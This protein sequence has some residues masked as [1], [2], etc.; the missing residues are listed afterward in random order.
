M[1]KDGGGGGF[2]QVSEG[3]H[4]GVCYSIYDLGT[5]RDDK[6]QKDVHKVLLI[7]ELPDERIEVE[8]NGEKKDLPRV[9]SKKYTLSLGE[10]A[11]LRKDLQTWRG[12]AFTPEELKGFDLKNVLSKNC[13]LQVIHTT[14]E[15][16]KTYANVA[17]II[18]MPKNSAKF[19]PENPVRFFSFADGSLEIPD[20]TPDWIK[21]EIKA[22][23]EWQT[24][25]GFDPGQ[26]PESNPD[27]DIPF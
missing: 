21:D 8:R 16:G 14:K 1:A 7:W 17:A 2:E 22:S 5:H 25:S 13:Q 23:E 10:K 9:I 27:D 24:L 4:R 20:G 12:R 6:Y 18:P 19:S 3:V 26:Q 15:K 11:T